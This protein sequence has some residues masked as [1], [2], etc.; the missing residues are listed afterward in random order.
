MLQFLLIP[1]LVLTF[2]ASTHAG[3]FSHED[4][5]HEKQLREQVQQ[6]QHQNNDLKIII[7]VLGVGSVASFV[8][9]TMVGSKTRRKSNEN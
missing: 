4:H 7:A 5:E 9:G 6:E 3:W 2:Q 1:I 8:G